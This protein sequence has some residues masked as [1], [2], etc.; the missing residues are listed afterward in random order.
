[1]VDAELVRRKMALILG[2]LKTLEPLAKK[3]LDEYLESKVD[4]LV[5]ERLLQRVIGRMI[6]VNYHLMTESGRPPPRDYYQSFH[7]LGALGVVPPPF[8][9]RIAA[10]A[11]LRERLVHEYDEIDP[12]KVHEA[13]V[14]ALAEVPEYLRHVDSHLD[15][16]QGDSSGSE[17][18]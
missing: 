7:E 4:E 1:M 16:L 15:Q 12:V 8:A 3:D 5:A 10:A 17:G 11:G 6:D 18:G 13:A 2:D 14:S 9:R